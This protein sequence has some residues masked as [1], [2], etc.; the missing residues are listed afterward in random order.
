MKRPLLPLLVLLLSANVA[1]AQSSSKSTSLSVSI[2]PYVHLDDTALP[3]DIADLEFG[4]NPSTNTLTGSN[5]PQ[6]VKVL[7]NASGTGA[8]LSLAVTSTGSGTGTVSAWDDLKLHITGSSTSG[9]TSLNGSSAGTFNARQCTSNGTCSGI[10]VS[11]IK[12]GEY[13]YT[14]NYQTE[15]LSRF[16]LAGARSFTALYTVALN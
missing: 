4:I 16:A 3:G 11:T 2:T 1:V 12:G 8:S 14:V 5:R 6:T 10:L 7:T 13:T 9:P 15:L